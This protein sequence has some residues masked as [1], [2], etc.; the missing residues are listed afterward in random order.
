MF[1]K[2]QDN[3]I[4]SVSFINT[5]ALP[6]QCEVIGDEIVKTS[7]GHEGQ[8][9]LITYRNTNQVWKLIEGLLNALGEMSYTD[10]EH[11][12]NKFKKEVEEQRNKF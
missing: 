3:V 4:Q 5:Q 6:I 8:K 1:D 2:Y 11:E 12:R 9:E 10:L 7:E